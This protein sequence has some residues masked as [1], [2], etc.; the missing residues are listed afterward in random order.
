MKT[1]IAIIAAASF[2]ASAVHAEEAKP[3]ATG[4]TVAVSQN[5]PPTGLSNPALTFG[6]LTALAVGGFILAVAL[7]D[8]DNDD[9]NA[10][11]GTQ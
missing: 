2:A 6:A 9:N 1:A 10:T 5:L 7:D 3:A 11:N 4:Q 8:D